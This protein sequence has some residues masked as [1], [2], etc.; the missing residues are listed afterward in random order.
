MSL[1]PAALA[2]E[3][4]RY[5]LVGGYNTVIGYGIFAA[6]Y[7]FL[8][9]QIHYLALLLFSHVIAVTNAYHAYRLFVFRHG[10][11]GLH[12]YLRFHSVYLVSLGFNL[13]A[14]P[15]F[16]EIVH[17]GPMLSQA[18]VLTITVVMSYILHKRFS[19]G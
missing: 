6:L 14:L 9:H 8:G 18:I 15:F 4:F 17:F 1:L 19:F 7:L 2:S 3:K 16:V 10:K 11:T 5:L 13:I 12:S